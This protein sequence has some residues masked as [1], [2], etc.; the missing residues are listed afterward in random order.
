MTHRDRAAEPPGQGAG[1]REAA[2]DPG[3]A[4][5]RAG[6]PPSAAATPLLRRTG[7]QG[8]PTPAQSPAAGSPARPGWRRPQVLWAK[9]FGPGGG[10]R[11]AWLAMPRIAAPCAPGRKPQPGSMGGSRL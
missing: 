7:R 5:A 4:E 6:H 1:R 8:L 10:R 3:F 9:A 11:P 2:G